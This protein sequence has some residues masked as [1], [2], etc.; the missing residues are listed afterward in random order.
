MSIQEIQN[1]LK[2]GLSIDEVCTKYNLT[3]L[4][5]FKLMDKTKKP[6][7]EHQA[8]TRH[9]IKYC[10]RFI[11]VKTIDSKQIVFGS[12]YD[13]QEAIQTRDELVRKNWNVNRDEYLGDMY[14]TLRKN[15]YV[16]TKNKKRGKTIF[17]G[18]YSTLRDARKVRDELVKANWNKNKLKS[19][20]EK[21]GVEK[22]GG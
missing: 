11:I 18:A 12:Y 5:I 3:F 13:L 7:T 6:R 2:K 15:R 9:I 22:I 8:L 21:T 19:I 17:F 10:N 4:E 14:I 20:L 16:V 1:D